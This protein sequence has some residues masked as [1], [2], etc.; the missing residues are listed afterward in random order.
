MCPISCSRDVTASLAHAPT[1]DLS[2]TWCLVLGYM[3]KPGLFTHWA[4]SIRVTSCL[5]SL[6]SQRF[7][8]GFSRCSLCGTDAVSITQLLTS[9]TKQAHC[10]AHG[11]MCAWLGTQ[12]FSSADPKILSGRF[13]FWSPR[14]GDHTF[15]RAKAPHLQIFVPTR[16]FLLFFFQKK[17]L[18]QLLQG[19]LLAKGQRPLSGV[20]HF[21]AN[22]HSKC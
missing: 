12:L 13:F 11:G 5:L 4:C 16:P 19:P 9:Q 20:K 1:R 17:F 2:K 10:T 6:F 15:I 22:Q 3:Y 18:S 14:L 7:C 21:A 8:V